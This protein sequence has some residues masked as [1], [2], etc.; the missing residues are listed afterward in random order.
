MTVRRISVLDV[1]EMIRRFRLGR[2]SSKPIRVAT[3]A[4]DVIGCLRFVVRKIDCEWN[5]LQPTADHFM[6]M[7][8]WI[9]IP[10]V[11]TQVTVPMSIRFKKNRRRT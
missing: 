9:S 10:P 3:T 8:V 7:V 5:L 11:Q 4:G 2:Q 1:R 6:G